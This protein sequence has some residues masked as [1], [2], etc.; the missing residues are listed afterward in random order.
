MAKNKQTN[1]DI[2]EA[3]KALSAAASEAIKTIANAATEAKSVVSV[4]AAEAARVLSVTNSGDHDLL[5]K[6]DTKVDQIQADVTD[7]KKNNVI[8]VTQEQHKS[9]I[10]KSVDQEDRLRVIETFKN[11]S[12][13]RNTVLASGISIV[14]TI[15]ILLVNKFVK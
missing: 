12:L 7:L 11:N 14:I 13:G 8:Y 4:N 15:I 6:L 3:I 5:T 9:L 1:Q 2:Q 10:D